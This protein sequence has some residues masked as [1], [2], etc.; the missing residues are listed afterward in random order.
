M[1]RR[2]W[3]GG[4]ALLAVTAGCGGG[5]APGAPIGFGIAAVT[6]DWPNPGATGSYNSVR[7]VVSN[8]SAVVGTRLVARPAQGASSTVTLD[9]VPAATLNLVETGYANADGSGSSQALGST[10]FN[11]KPG[12]TTR[13]SLRNGGTSETDC[14]VSPNGADSNFGSEAAPW[15]TLQ[16]AAEVAGPGDTVIIADG[17]Y[18]G[19]IRITQPGTSTQPVIF[20]AANPGGPIIRGDQTG[21]KDAVILIGAHWT[22]LEGLTVM[23]GDRGIRVDQSDHVIIRKCR[24]IDSQT[25]GIFVDYSDDLLIELN[26]CS[27]TKVQHGI[28][29]SSSGDRPIVRGNICHDNARCG[30]QLNGGWHALRPDFGKRGDGI[31]EGAVVTNNVI[32][33]CGLDATD[34]GAAINLASVRN[35]TIAG[36]LLYNNLGSGIAL[37]NDS[38]SDVVQWGSKQNL[39][40]QNTVYFRQGDGRWCMSLKHGSTGN[41]LQNNLLSGGL[42]GAL[43]FDTSSSFTSDGNLF[44]SLAGTNIATNADSVTYYTLASW[45]LLG[46]QDL[47]SVNSD[48]GFAAAAT[49]ADFMLRA[50]SPA[51]GIGLPLTFPLTDLAG[52]QFGA[53]GRW[54]AGCYSGP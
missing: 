43:E 19:G 17:D 26:E 8:G 38:T 45:R 4:C 25:Q 52:K 35:S 44:F 49:Q 14:F 42:R 2:R 46:N 6:V 21:S 16:R 53:G 12:R 30:I 54:D 47:H 5:G 28:Y 29:V 10:L 1:A 37:F 13:V 31:I 15:R 27:G 51:I 24:C 33:N 3:L 22:V 11:V 39:L 36:N 7:T 20:R 18:P 48:P 9:S 50:G 41:I 32:Y 23:R 34:R 40:A